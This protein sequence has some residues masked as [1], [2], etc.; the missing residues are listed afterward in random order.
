MHARCYF[1]KVFVSSL[2]KKLYAKIFFDY[3]TF[4]RRILL[5]FQLITCNFVLQADPTAHLALSLANRA[6]VLVKLKFFK[7]ATQENMWRHLA[8]F[9]LQ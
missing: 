5:I 9:F 7:E 4:M 6:A 3:M 8:N 2:M 1:S